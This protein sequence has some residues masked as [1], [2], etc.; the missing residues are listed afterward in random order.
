MNWFFI[1]AGGI[2]LLLLVELGLRLHVD[3]YAV[4]L[5]AWYRQAAPQGGQIKDDYFLPNSIMW[6]GGDY[7]RARPVERLVWK[8]REVAENPYIRPYDYAVLRPY[9]LM[10]YGV[11]LLQR[12]MVLALPLLLWF[13]ELGWLAF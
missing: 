7:W 12:G 13:E 11:I 5:L 2:V 1:Y 3:K 8:Q 9:V 10:L 4:P 6:R